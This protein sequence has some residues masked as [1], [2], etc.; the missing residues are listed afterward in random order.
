MQ[1]PNGM[2]LVT[3]PTGSGKTTTLYS[4]LRETDRKKL[5]VITVE[6]PVEYE[7]DHVVQVPISGKIG[8]GFSTVLR[9]ILRHDP[10]LVMVG[11]IRDEETA[12]I[13]LQAS[14]TGHLVLATLH[15]NDAPGAITRLMEM[16]LEPFLIASTLR[17]VLAQRLMRKLCPDCREALPSRSP[18]LASLGGFSA[19]SSS[20]IFE[21]KGCSKCHGFGYVGR[22]AVG[23]FLPVSP[24]LRERIAEGASLEALRE[25]ACEEG[26]LTLPEI[27]R[28]RVLEGTSSLEEYLR[29]RTSIATG[30]GRAS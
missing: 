14:L 25:V 10:D 11:E 30:G 13:S 23:E 1:K 24:R 16:G 29:F 19:V 7:L 15:T 4:C 20:R 26:M 6:D 3:G 27:A 9:S 21:A 2:I 18:I 28:T 5:K 17:G 8:L 22:I 12:K